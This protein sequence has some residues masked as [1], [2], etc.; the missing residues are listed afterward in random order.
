[1]EIMGQ[2]SPWAA[3]VERFDREEDK[4]RWTTTIDEGEHSVD[5][6][7]HYYAALHPVHDP[8][9]L[10]RALLRQPSGRLSLLPEGEARL[11]TLGERSITTEKGIRTVRHFAVHGLDL[12]P[13]YV[14]LDESSTTFA[15]EWSVL[16]GW[17]TAFPELRLATEEALAEY[18]RGIARS[19]VPPARDRPFAI[20]G[21]RLFD[22]QTHAVRTGTTILIDGNRIATVGADGSVEVPP[23]A[24]MIEAAGRMVLP[25]LWDMHAHHGIPADELLAPLHLAGDHHGA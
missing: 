13:A 7:A 21:A 6:P 20:T 5:G 4:Y 10:V 25:G 24:E 2:K 11:E 9:V 8:G 1:M 12:K 15:D 18:H 22:P 16:S 14:W 17:E 23:G 19:L 3:W